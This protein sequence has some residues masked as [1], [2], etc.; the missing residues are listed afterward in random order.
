MAKYRGQNNYEIGRFR[1]LSNC[2]YHT[3][4]FCTYEIGAYM[5]R[6]FYLT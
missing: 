1:A 6:L 5:I 2:N 4:D 3:T